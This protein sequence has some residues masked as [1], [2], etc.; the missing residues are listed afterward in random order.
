MSF[1]S[2]WI[3]TGS[4][5]RHETAPQEFQLLADSGCPISRS[6]FARCGIPQILTVRLQG[7]RKLRSCNERAVES[8]I[9]RKTS[10]IWGTRD[11]WSGQ[12]DLQQ[13]TPK[14]DGPRLAWQGAGQSETGTSK[15]GCRLV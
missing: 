6:F 3:W 9:S 7:P 4:R 11:R 1:C 15:G 5:S 13:R 8:H 12:R 2:I 10:E 14:R